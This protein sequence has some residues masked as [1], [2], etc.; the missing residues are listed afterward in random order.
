[1]IKRILYFGNPA[2]LKVKDNQLVIDLPETKE[3]KTAAI[4][5]IGVIVLD[6]PQITITHGTIARLLDN[7]TALI[8]CDEKH[9]PTGYL[10]PLESHSLQSERFRHQIEASEALKKQL[11]QQTIQAKIKNQAELLNQ[12]GYSPK[13]MQQWVAEVKSGDEG[14]HEAVA[15]AHYWQRL[16]KSQIEFFYRDRY[17]E[18][19][20]HLLNY[21]Y[22]ILRGIV[23]WITFCKNSAFISVKC[24]EVLSL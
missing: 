4:E 17:G 12:A 15:A 1:M 11:W 21:G 5:D 7:N 6:H 13:K 8:T 9:L 23:T 20:N 19:P 22:A 24:N 2:Y 3:T 18:A 10:L 16:F 14:N